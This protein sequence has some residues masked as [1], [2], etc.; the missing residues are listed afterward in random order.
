MDSW[1]KHF[2]WDWLW[3]S[4]LRN[5]TGSTLLHVVH[6]CESGSILKMVV[7]GLL[8]VPLPLVVP[9]V[10]LVV[11]ID[12]G[13]W[14]DYTL[15]HTLHT[16]RVIFNA[17]HPFVIGLAVL[18][19]CLFLYEHV[20]CLLSLSMEDGRWLEE[21]MQITCCKGKQCV[22]FVFCLCSCL[23]LCPCLWIRRGNAGEH[24]CQC[25]GAS[26]MATGR[27]VL[28]VSNPGLCLLYNVPTTH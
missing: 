5:R 11:S 19:V 18:L 27:L 20:I 13:A 21:E 15:D 22:L 24:Q 28:L 16:L 3:Y 14:D 8:I 12:W 4:S 25:V 17:L 7:V 2:S 23:C 10:L 1:R 26:F 6:T 9:V